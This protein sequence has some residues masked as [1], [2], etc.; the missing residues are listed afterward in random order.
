MNSQQ[1]TA[2]A[3]RLISIWLLVEL[4][5]NLPS[6]VLVLSSVDQ[7]QQQEIPWGAYVGIIGAGS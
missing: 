5:L 6:L 4:V 1:V 3:L 2:I 7:Y